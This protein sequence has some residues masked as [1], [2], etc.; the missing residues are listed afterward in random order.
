MGLA[1]FAEAIAKSKVPVPIF[2]I[3]CSYFFKGQT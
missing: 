3:S 1:L 2:H